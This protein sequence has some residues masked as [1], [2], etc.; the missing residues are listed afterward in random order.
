ME[1]CLNFNGHENEFNQLLNSYSKK[2]PDILGFFFGPK[3]SGK[4][5]TFLKFVEKIYAN[6]KNYLQNLFEINGDDDSAFIE[7]ILG[8]LFLKVY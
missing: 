2:V 6:K 5:K 8:I 7:K 1:N 4:Y 3:G